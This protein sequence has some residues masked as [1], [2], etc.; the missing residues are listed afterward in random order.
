M[1]PFGQPTAAM[2]NGWV[3]TIEKSASFRK[4]RPCINTHFFRKIYVWAIFPRPALSPKI[5][6][7]LR[8]H[9]SPQRGEP[10]HGAGFTLLLRVLVLSHRSTKQRL[11]KFLRV[12]P[13][14]DR[15]R[16]H[17]LISNEAGRFFRF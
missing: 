16:A 1:L 10:P 9:Q 2:S 11:P 6:A 13:R 5:L 14:P 3:T 4:N 17:Q 7:A 8:V 15:W 12:R